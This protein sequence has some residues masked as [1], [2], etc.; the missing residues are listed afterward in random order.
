MSKLV[1]S[2]LLFLDLILS[3]VLLLNLFTAIH[4][5]I[6]LRHYTEEKILNAHL[7]TGYVQENICRSI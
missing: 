4:I 1:V 5:K 2:P 6:V 7:S 3:F